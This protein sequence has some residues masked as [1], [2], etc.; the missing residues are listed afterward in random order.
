[1]HRAALDLA[2]AMPMRVPI[3]AGEDQLRVTVQIV[4]SFS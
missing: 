3:R 2:A 1:M 4:W